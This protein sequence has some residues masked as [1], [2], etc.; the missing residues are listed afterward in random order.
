MKKKMIN[1]IFSG[2]L[3]TICLGLLIYVAFAWY[4]DNKTAQATD[5]SFSTDE[6]SM[7]GFSVNVIGP[8]GKGVSVSVLPDE[9]TELEINMESKISRDVNVNMRGEMHWKDVD[10]TN[11]TVK[12]ELVENDATKVQN[13][14]LSR[15]YLV[16]EYYDKNTNLKVEL[17]DDEKK[18]I[19]KSFYESQDND[20]NIINKVKYFVSDTKIEENNYYEKLL[21]KLELS[22]NNP[23][24]DVDDGFN[25]TAHI[26][27]DSYEVASEYKSGTAYYTRSGE[28][29][30]E[31]PY[32]Y[33]V[34]SDVTSENFSAN[35]YY[36]YRN[37]NAKLYVYFYFDPTD[38]KF[39]NGNYYFLGQNPYFYQWIK[40]DV[41][42]TEEHND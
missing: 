20:Y 23:W 10:F 35:T 42:V 21:S 7:T 32:V 29:S 37:Y 36:I 31:D 26:S 19:F 30:N 3:S 14:D 25:F 18:N 2:L 15:Y 6:M 11:N 38:E 28:G 33:S 16:N 27:D 40:F 5:I 24:K 13:T 12:T 22:E 34:A 8:G 4:I 39:Y 9:I 41:L 1:L 17:T